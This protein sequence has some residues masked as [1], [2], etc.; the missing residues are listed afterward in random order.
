MFGIK[1]VPPWLQLYKSINPNIF[2]FYICDVKYHNFSD[3]MWCPYREVPP[4]PS[5]PIQE[6]GH[7]RRDQ[8]PSRVNAQ[9][10]PGS[11]WN[12]PQDLGAGLIKKNSKQSERQYR[13]QDVSVRSY[14]LCQCY[15]GFITAHHLGHMYTG[16]LK[17][18][19]FFLCFLAACPHENS[20]WRHWKLSYCK[21]LSRV[22]IFRNSTRK[23][24]FLSSSVQECSSYLFFD[25]WKDCAP[26]LCGLHIVTGTMFTWGAFL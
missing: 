4:L 10:Y 1:F 15:M 16:I 20:I 24:L 26:C 6:S 7:H 9:A 23:T 12:G 5:A 19:F 21:T 22:N 11:M 25:V 18:F 14:S 17:T 3:V 8:H 13:K 2:F